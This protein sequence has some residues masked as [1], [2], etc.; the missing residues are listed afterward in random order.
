MSL[1]NKFL[2]KTIRKKSALAH[3]Y[4]GD[5]DNRL[6]S[7]DSNDPG[8]DEQPRYDNRS[9][10]VIGNANNSNNIIN[11]AFTSRP[12]NTDS[13][14]QDTT[15]AEVQAQCPT[16]DY[17]HLNNAVISQGTISSSL[18]SSKTAGPIAREQSRKPYSRTPPV[19]N[20]PG[21]FS[22]AKAR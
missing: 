15:R 2:D 7:H 6:G 18:P 5:P 20:A 3:H 17:A 16:V 8:H 1:F 19:N 13:G 4:T 10:A 12:S 22:G 9:G 21:G 11:S 14:F